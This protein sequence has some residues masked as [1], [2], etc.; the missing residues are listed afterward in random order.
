MQQQQQNISEARR[1]PLINLTPDT[2]QQQQQNI[3]EARRQPLPLNRNNDLPSTSYSQE[4]TFYGYDDSFNDSFNNPYGDSPYNLPE[5]SG[6]QM[7]RE[8]PYYQNQYDSTYGQPQQFIPI[9]PDQ[10]VEKYKQW[11]TPSGMSR[12]AVKLA[13]ESYFGENVLGMCTPQGRSEQ[14]KLPREP[15]LDL[16]LYLVRLFPTLNNAEF[17][18]YWKVC[19]TSIGQACKSIR[20]NKNK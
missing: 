16:K 1:H 7:L 5:Q 8:S 6:Y 11:K 15:L 20:K 9:H 19:L 2:Q 4:E 3:S 13:R 14:D 17:E 12:L 18:G 10:V